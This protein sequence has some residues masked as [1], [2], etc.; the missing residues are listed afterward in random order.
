M[1]PFIVCSEHTAQPDLP[2]RIKNNLPLEPYD[3]STFYSSKIPEGYSDYS[4]AD[5]ET[6][7]NYKRKETK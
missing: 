5:P 2:A 6:E 3:R 7:A 1:A 4:F